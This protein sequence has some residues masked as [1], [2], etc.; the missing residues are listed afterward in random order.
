MSLLETIKVR[1]RVTDQC[2]HLWTTRNQITKQS[3]EESKEKDTLTNREELKI[4]RNL[5][6]SFQVISNLCPIVM[7]IKNPPFLSTISSPLNI[8]NINISPSHPLLCNLSLDTCQWPKRDIWYVP[9][10]YPPPCLRWIEI[11]SRPSVCGVSPIHLDNEF[12]GAITPPSQSHLL[13]LLPS[14]SS[15]KR[16][17]EEKSITS[18]YGMLLHPKILHYQLPVTTTRE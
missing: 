15:L 1:W 9:V 6:L 4:I 11:F 18:D 5:R 12:K 14:S 8:S 10:P 13:N 3:Q 7:L 2:D 17:G 16:Q